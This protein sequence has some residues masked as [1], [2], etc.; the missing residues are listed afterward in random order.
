M[1]HSK[2]WHRYLLYVLVVGSLGT[3]INSI[4]YVNEYIPTGPEGPCRRLSCPSG[5]SQHCSDT[6]SLH[7]LV[8]MCVLVHVLGAM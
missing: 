1:H 6:G 8:I 7:V 3:S 4:N 5:I 2:T